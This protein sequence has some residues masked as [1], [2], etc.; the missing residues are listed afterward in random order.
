MFYFDYQNGKY[1]YNTEANRGADTFHPFSDMTEIYN[2][3]VAKGVTPASD[4]PEDIATAISQIITDVKHSVHVRWWYRGDNNGP[5]FG[6]E[7]TVDG[8]RVGGSDWSTTTD[9]YGTV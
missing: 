3:V 5:T 6:Y 9:W 4:S 7:A 1:G 8:A 2:A